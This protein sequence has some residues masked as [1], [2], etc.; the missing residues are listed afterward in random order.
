MLNFFRLNGIFDKP[1]KAM[2]LKMI[3]SHGYYGCTKC[4][5]KG[6]DDGSRIIFEFDKKNPEHMINI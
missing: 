5:I 4:E 1:A 2:V 6:Y 3:S